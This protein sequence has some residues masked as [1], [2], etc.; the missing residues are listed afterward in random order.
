M[1]VVVIIP[2]FNEE[3]SIG[4]VLRD[5]PMELVH[6]V[7]VVDNHSSDDTAAVA[8]SGGAT[9]VSEPRRGYGNACMAGIAHA[10]KSRPDTIVFL[11]GDYSDYPEEMRDL[12]AKIQEGFDLVIGS[13]MMGKAEPGALLPQAR[14][15][16]R[17]AVSLIKLLFGGEFTDLGPFRAIK[18]SKLLELKMRDPTFG[19]TVE[20]QVKAAKFGLRTTEVPVRYR[21]RVGVSKITGT[22]SGTIKAGY[23]ILYTIFKYALTR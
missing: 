20:M 18:W 22:M 14:W 3:Q 8:K 5:I 13:R 6:E 7:I 17:L 12:V 16:N 4:M 19:W 11:D 2:A 15:G 21:A 9:V 23:K 10:K 1:K